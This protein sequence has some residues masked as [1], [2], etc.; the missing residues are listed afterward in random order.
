M[1]KSIISLVLVIALIS[2]MSIIPAAASA[3][4]GVSCSNSAQQNFNYSQNDIYQLLIKYIKS[5]NINATY[6]A[7]SNGAA[8]CQTGTC[9]EDTV[10]ESCGSC[11]GLAES[12]C[13]T[14][15]TCE[16]CGA[17]TSCENLAADC[18]NTCGE[19][20]TGSS[21]CYNS[22]PYSYWGYYSGNSSNSCNQN[23]NSSSSCS[24]NS[25]SSQNSST[26]SSNSTSSG[27]GSCEFKDMGGYQI[28]S[29][30]LWNYVK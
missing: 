20:K 2:S 17:C 23:S 9:A 22:T 15:D 24:N 19:E 16:E 1:K 28:Y 10:C 11:E 8:T 26:Q 27:S 6:P 5:Q 18:G 29:R 30:P 21:S 4:Q 7:T 25:S 3:P 12:A 13:T 14:C